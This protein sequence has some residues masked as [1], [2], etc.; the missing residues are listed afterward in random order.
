M[1]LQSPLA[2]ARGL[3]AAGEGSHDWW[4]QRV[5]AIALVPLTFWFAAAVAR[6]PGMDYAAVRH[7]LAAPWNS[8]LLLAFIIAA[9]YHTM[10]GLQVIIEDYIPEEGVKILS[11]VAM[12]LVFFFLGLAACYATLRIALAG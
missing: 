11:L 4:R 8:V 5:T 9:A 12:K 3:G 6:L 7:W 1:N 2:R 10:L